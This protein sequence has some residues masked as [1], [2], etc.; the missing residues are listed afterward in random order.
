MELLNK[1]KI[2][3]DESLI[4]NTEYY[5]ELKDQVHCPIC[6]NLLCEP[7]MCSNCEHVYCGDCFKT[8][9]KKNDY[10]PSL[11]PKKPDTVK[12]VCKLFSKVLNGIKLRCKYGCEVQLLDY[13]THTIKCESDNKPVV[14]FNC[15]KPSRNCEVI[16][17][18][19]DEVM[20]IRQ[21]IEFYKSEVQD[22][23]DDSEKVI[24]D[25]AKLKEVKEQT[26]KQSEEEIAKI[27]ME[28]QELAKDHANLR[29]SIEKLANKT[30]IFNNKSDYYFPIETR[31]HAYFVNTLNP[32]FKITNLNKTITKMSGDDYWYG[33]FCKDKVGT[34]GT[35]EF[36]VKIDKIN[37]IASIM[38][39]FAVGGTSFSKGLFSSDTSWMCYLHGGKFY[40]A[41]D[42]DEYFCSRN[43]IVRPCCN[44]ILSVC[45]NTKTYVVYVKINGTKI[46]EEIKMNIADNQKGNLYPCIDLAKIGDQITLL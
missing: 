36:S 21:E 27:K 25:I 22:K 34:Q 42:S 44:D 3:P 1:E 46:P 33:F 15:G 13:R 7:L 41:S 17:K 4:I 14:C 38:V 19:E 45:I 40:N 2:K 10:C 5:T 23:I 39:G 8:W 30:T 29:S 18:S 32:D 11:C 6:F 35:Y 12:E 9:L 26:I 28:H 16:I 20:Q 24:K 31:I 43:M 37:D